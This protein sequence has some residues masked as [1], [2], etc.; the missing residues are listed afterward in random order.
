[1]SLIT[2]LSV[3]LVLQVEQEKQLIHQ[4]LLSAETTGGP[5]HSFNLIDGHCHCYNDWPG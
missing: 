4:A 1:M 3:S 2:Y 5:N